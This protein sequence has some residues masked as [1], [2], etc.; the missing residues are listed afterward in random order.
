MKKKLIVAGILILLL[1]LIAA[2]ACAEINTIRFSQTKKG[3]VKITWKDGSY[4]GKYQVYYKISNWKN[5][6]WYEEDYY[7]EKSATL[8]Y[9]IPGATYKITIRRK[10]G[11]SSKTK[12]Y[13]VPKSTFMD[14]TTGKSVVVQNMKSFITGQDSIYKNVELRMYYPR[15][16]K[17]RDYFCML[18]LKT[19]SGYTSRV[20]AWPTLTLG[21]NTKYTYWKIDFSTWMKNVKE[22]FGKYPKGE[23]KYEL[24]LDGTYYQGGNF[25]VY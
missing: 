6:S 16:R 4:K 20:E 1:T 25:F 3:H 22:T 5:G 2:I 11:T 15:I 24:Y 14:W 17:N 8:N 7:D 10:D 18:V 21:R 12:K 13:T 9:L 19:P 23:Y